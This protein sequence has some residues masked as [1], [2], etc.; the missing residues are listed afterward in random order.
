MQ[1]KAAEEGEKEEKLH[2]KIMCYRENK[3]GDFTGSIEK[4]KAKIES[5]GTEMKKPAERKAQMEP[6]LKEP[7]AVLTQRWQWPK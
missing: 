6:E 7:Q 3:V 2:E 5:L 1:T 4:A